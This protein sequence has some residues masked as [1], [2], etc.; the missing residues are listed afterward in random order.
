MRPRLSG[1][2]GWRK[3]GHSCVI[4]LALAG[5]GVAP[6]LAQSYPAKPIRL[7]V[8]FGPGGPTDVAARFVAQVAR[9][10]RPGGKF[11]FVSSWMPSLWSWRYWASRTFN[12]AMHA[13]NLLPGPPFVMY[14]L[15]FLMP[16]AMARLES[17]GFEVEVRERVFGDGFDHMVLVIATRT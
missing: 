12:A 3:L 7:I 14:Y 8:P 4:A 6:A 5:S 17:A 11:V 2:R 15:R 13:R 9:A 1:M 16:E 10:L